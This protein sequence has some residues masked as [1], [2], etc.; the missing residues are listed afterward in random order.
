M[1]GLNLLWLGQHKRR[2][3]SEASQT[4]SLLPCALFVFALALWPAGAADVSSA[5]VRLENAHL[6]LGFDPGNGAL[7][8]FV[9]VASRHNFVAA[10]PITNT[11][12]VVE[13]L[14]G[15]KVEPP[16]ALEF[17]WERVADGRG[18]WLIWRGFDS[19]DA[20]FAG[21]TV[22]ALVTL[23]AEGPLSRWSLSIGS[24]GRMP[25]QI[26]FP[27]LPNLAE[28]TNEF[29]L[30]PSW[31]GQIHDRPRELFSATNNSR[32]RIEWDYPGHTS[33]QCV[34]L[35]SGAGPG[36]YF[37]CDDTNAYRK[38]FVASG[39]ER[40][41]VGLEML[42]LPEAGL[43]RDYTLPYAAVVGV[44]HGDWLAA[45]EQYRGWATNQYW[46]K[47]SRRAR[48]LTP[49][50]A[51]N[52]GLWVWN[53][54]RSE[55]VLPPALTLREQLGLPVSVFWHW[56]HGCSYDSGFPEYLPPREGV[57]SFT[58][59]L[60]SAQQRGVRGIV[61]MNQRLWGMTT[62]SWK[63]EGA[64]AFAVK[65]AKGVVHP[66]IYN[67]FTQ[68]PCASMCLDTLFWRN[69]YAGLAQT[70]VRELGVD[71]IYMDQACS[72]LACFDP[73]HGHPVGGGAYWMQGFQ[74]LAADIRAR[75]TGGDLALAGEGVGES[76][77]PH[78]DLMLSLQV[79][80]E[81]SNAPDGWEPVPFF[82]AVYHPF[83]F[84]YGNYSSLTMPPYDELWPQETAPKEPLQLL[85]RKFS[86]Q[87]R[88][89]QARAFVW[90]QQPTLANFRP[91]HL[92]ERGEEMA[93][94]LRLARLRERTLKYLRDGVFMRPPKLDVAEELIPMSRL[95]IYAGQKEGLKTFEKW[96]P[97]VLAGAWRAPDG[98]LGVALVNISELPVTFMI[99]L[100]RSDSGLPEQGT[101]FQV[102]EIEK[103]AIGVFRGG[104]YEQAH[105]LAGPGAYLLEFTPDP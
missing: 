4:V 17:R 48:G 100:D 28:Q 25:Y 43:G 12:W 18:L 93:F 24:V 74:K 72:S 30:V 32:R 9:D 54:G 2:L 23:D 5:L 68:D 91:E 58:N 47:A 76:W 89:E 8:E 62:A 33:M 88:L 64:E 83:V 41:R 20:E 81:R 59:A 97:P 98:N 102:D 66:E 19:Q 82:Q 36:L 44:F 26:A 78:L 52:T 45:A 80:R 6:R 49:D 90:G 46:A 21:A 92:P 60:A 10:P 70:V 42:H 16:Q 37:S 85:D 3:K 55:Q 7:R 63:A 11:L 105:T 39:G 95:S 79:S 96:V 29:L 69:K 1:S 86:T 101:V 38:A 103:K 51:E 77:L 71:G 27:R 84:Q 87:F 15:A 40:R 61:Y 31:M 104:H 22:E 65:N 99:G 94:A 14:N 53:R 57:G 73:A 75:C 50:W 56:W 35:G 13:A 34:A 67:T